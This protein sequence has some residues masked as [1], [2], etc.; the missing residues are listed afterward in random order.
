MRTSS[1]HRLS[2][3]TVAALLT[4]ATCVVGVTAAGDMA[5]AG[6]SF[7]K[8]GGWGKQ[9]SGNGQFRA[10]AYGLATDKAGNVYIADTDNFRVQMFSSKGAFRPSRL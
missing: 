7:K 6:P 8:V 2:G 9:G 4:A 5:Q 1:R 10:N 3:V